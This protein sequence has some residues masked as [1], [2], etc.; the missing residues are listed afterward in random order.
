MQVFLERD[1]ARVLPIPYWTDGEP[2][3]RFVNVKRKPEL[4]RAIPELRGCP[5]LL[6]FVV[7]LNGPESRFA[8]LGC[9]HWT[10]L[11][12]RGTAVTYEAGIYVDLVLD[13]LETASGRKGYLELFRRLRERGERA[14]KSPLTVVRLQPQRVFFA[15]LGG[16]P[17]WMLSTWVF[18]AG[19]SLE[20]AKVRRRR[21]LDEVRKLCALVSREVSDRFGDSGTRVPP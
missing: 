14:G 19:S 1:E 2:D 7:A 20:A 11:A 13:R 3:R 18:G 15:K 4:V 5:E 21:A 6:D 17:M 16:D 12:H 10:K 8:T 9:D